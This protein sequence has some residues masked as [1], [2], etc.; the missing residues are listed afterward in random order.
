MHTIGQQQI[1]ACTA[2]LIPGEDVNN[3][4]VFTWLAPDG[5]SIN[6]ERVTIMPTV[7]NGTNHTSILYFDYLMESDV[8]AYQCDITSNRSSIP[9]S[10]ELGDL[11][12]K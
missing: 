7:V 5:V 2:T 1:I 12:S 11:L 9:Q 3:S 8:G 10:V 6:D 4:L